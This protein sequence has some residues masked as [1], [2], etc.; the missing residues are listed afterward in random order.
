V[1]RALHTATLLQDGRVLITGGFERA[2]KAEV[3]S[4]LPSAEIWAP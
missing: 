4:D 1:G 3:V 2:E